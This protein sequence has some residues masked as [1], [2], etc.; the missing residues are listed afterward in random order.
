MAVDLGRTTKA[1]MWQLRE[2]GDDPQKVLL[3]YER[4]EEKA[5]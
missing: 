3:R 2:Y 1:V 5:V 4:M